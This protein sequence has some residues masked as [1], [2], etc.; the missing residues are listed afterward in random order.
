M[1]FLAVANTGRVEMYTNSVGAWTTAA[2]LFA[3][4]APVTA[5][6][7]IS[8]SVSLF[9]GQKQFNFYVMHELII[10]CQ[11]FRMNMTKLKRGV[12]GSV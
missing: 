10:L 6:G 5:T 7:T 4:T 2:D 8:L 9:L 11:H 1:Y 12:R 3:T